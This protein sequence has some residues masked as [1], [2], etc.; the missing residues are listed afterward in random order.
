MKT[1]LFSFIF[2]LISVCL[3]AQPGTLDSAFGNNGK[4]ISTFQNYNTAESVLIEQDQKI[5]IA[6]RCNLG[7]IAVRYNT[8]GTIDSSFGNNGIF[9]TAELQ[10]TVTGALDKD[11]KIILAGTYN[12]EL[13]TIRL[14]HNGKIDSSYGKNGIASIV[15]TKSFT[16]KNIAIQND[17][18]ITITADHYDN[19]IVAARWLSNGIPDSS[20]GTAAISEA[21]TSIE[22][23]S[24]SVNTIAVTLD[25]KIVVAGAL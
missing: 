7:G 4:V 20:F 8:D 6:G 18:K 12:N 23:G 24:T 19:G 21:V 10:L 16:V 22:D 3:I 11:E 2:C 14:L 17:N 5:I 13:R 9:I 15:N 1:I 25:N